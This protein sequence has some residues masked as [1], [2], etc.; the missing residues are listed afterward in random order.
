MI[1][2][3]PPSILSKLPCGSM[4]RNTWWLSYNERVFSYVDFTS[5]CSTN[6][7]NPDKAIF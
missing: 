7:E 1:R 4:I 5:P 6:K 3:G 2:K